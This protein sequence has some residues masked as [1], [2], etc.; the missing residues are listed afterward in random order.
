VLKWSFGFGFIFVAYYTAE[1]V[2]IDHMGAHPGQSIMWNNIFGRNCN[3]ET[4][5]C[6]HVKF[7]N[8]EHLVLG[9]FVS[10]F[11]GAVIR[12]TRVWWRYLSYRSILVPPI[13]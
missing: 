1:T 7:F 2:Y 9:F 5:Y 12:V 4:H 8:P 11:I 6:Q 13:S 3:P 10:A